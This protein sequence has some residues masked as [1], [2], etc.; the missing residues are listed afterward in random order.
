[1]RRFSVKSRLLKMLQI[2]VAGLAYATA[3]TANGQELPVPCGGSACGPNG[4]AVWVA[5]GRATASVSGNTMT[6]NQQTDSATLNWASFN[7][8]PDGV[9][10]FN[11]P[12]ATSVALNRIFQN[13][14]SR[15]FGAL[16][17][18]GQVYLINQNGILFGETAVV[19]VAGLIAS[20]LDLTTE[21]L[22]SGIAGAARS[23]AAAFALFTDAEGNVLESAAVT[24]ESGAFLGAEGGQ[25]YLFAP[26]V[27][28]RGTIETPD[29]QT[30]L[31]AGDKVYLAASSDP[32]LR[33]LFVEVDGE[34]VVTNGEAANSGR[35]LES[36]VGEISAARGNITMAALAVNQLGRV[37]ATTS[38]RQNGSIRLVGQRN[39]T[40]QTIGD[41][42]LLLANEGGT[43]TLG[44]NSA[45]EVL[46]DLD[47]PSRTVDVNE[48]PTSIIEISG[49]DVD[50]LAGSHITATSGDVSITARAN[51]QTPPER[52]DSEPTDSRLYIA[53]DV[54]IDVS[55]ADATLS[56]EDN[57]IDVELLGNQLRDSP[58]QRDGPL[59]GETVQVDIRDSGTH[60]DGGTW[61]GTPL[62]DASGEIS[63]IERG[64]A[65]RN[66]TGGSLS[67]SS[68]GDVIVEA[69]AILD[70]SGG[71]TTYEGGEVTTSRVLGVDGRVYDMANADRDREYVMVVDAY[72]VEHPRWGVTEVFPGFP[73]ARPSFEEGYVEGKDAGTVNILTPRAVFDGQIRADIVAGRYQRLPATPV[74]E[75]FLYRPFDQLPL[76]G[77]LIVGSALGLGPPPNYVLGDVAFVGGNA[78]A[79]LL[80]ADGGDFDPLVDVL[81]DDYVTRIDPQLFGEGRVTDGSVFSNGQ[82]RYGEET[83]IVLPAQGS[84]TLNGS[85][86]LF[87]GGFT[88]AGGALTIVGEQTV[89][90]FEDVFVDVGAAATI[91]VA[92]LWT[93][94]NPLLGPATKPI[95]IDGGSVELVASRGDLSVA[96]GSR[97]D[98]S[99][100]A[101]RTDGGS[102][103][104]GSGGSVA[105]TATARDAGLPV[106][107]S[108]GAELIGYGLFDGASLLISANSICIADENCVDDVNE[109]WLTPD[110]YM[111]QGF[112][113]I[114]LASNLVGL[115]LVAGTQI[116]GQQRNFVLESEVASIVSGTSLATFANVA[117]LPEVDR[118]PMRLALRSSN[119][120]IPGFNYDDYLTTPGL[121]LGVDTRIDMDAG[122]AVSLA[123][124]ALLVV[125]GAIAARGGAVDMTLRNSLL[126]VVGQPPAG[127]WIGD[128]ASIDVSG[129]A[130]TQL[131]EFGLTR[132]RVLDGGSVSI[133]AQRDGISLAAGSTINVSGTA[134]ELDIIAGTLARPRFSTETIGSNG[135]SL[136]LAAAE[137]I[138]A[139][140]SV[141][142]AGGQAP[143]TA[144]GTLNVLMD[145]A[146]RGPDPRGGTQ[147]PILSLDARRILVSENWAPFLLGVGQEIPADLIGVARIDADLMESAGFDN[148]SLTAASLFSQRFGT[149][150]LASQG[151]IGFL[152][153]TS[154]TLPGYLLLDAPNISGG[155]GDVDLNANYVRLGHANRVTQ[156]TGDA[157]AT[158]AGGLTVNAGL[159]DFLGNIRVKG[160]EAIRFESRG[161]IRATGVQLRG[162]RELLGALQTD[163]ALTLAA[164]QIYPTTLSDFTFQVEG[165]GRSVDILPVPGEPQLLLSAGGRLTID[166]DTIRQSGVL[167]APFG[168]LVLRGRSAEFLDGSLTSTS[169]EASLVP[170]GTIQIG[171]DW[172]F[173]L[174][175]NETLVF[176][177]L[178]ND[179][180][181][182]NVRIDAEDVSLGSGAVIDVSA[183]GDLLAYEFVPGVGGSTDYLSA[184]ESPGLFAILPGASINFA[185]IDPTES[186][187]TALQIGDTVF[188]DGIGELPAGNYTLLPAR[189]ALLPG[190]LLISPV[191]GYTDIL[192]GQT[193]RGA[194]GS[195]IVSG[196]T[197]VRGTDVVGQ[198]RQG[199]ALL[200]RSRA[201]AEAQYELSVAS[202]FF[203]GTGVRT[204]VDAG[205]ASFTAANSLA[206]Q[207][208]LRADSEFGRG[209]AL[210]V[211]SDFL[212]VVD[213]ATGAEGTVEILASD[214]ESLGAESI[215]LGG[216]RTSTIDGDVVTVS[217]QNVEV[218]DG[219]SLEGPDIILVASNEVRVGAGAVLE[220]TESAIEAENVLVSGDAALVRV[221]ADRQGMLV[222]DA[223]SGGTGDIVI[224]EAA[225]LRSEGS[226]T[227]DASRDVDSDG[228]YDIDGGVLRLG[229]ASI[230]LGDGPANGGLQLGQEALAALDA[231]EIEFVSRGLIEVYGSITLDV[232]ERLTLAAAGIGAGVIDGQVEAGNLVL[233]APD[234]VLLGITQSEAPALANG[235][236]NLTLNSARLTVGDGQF[237]LQ[238][239]ENS[240]L[241][242]SDSVLFAGDGALQSAGDLSIAAG[243]FTLATGADYAVQAGGRLEL[244]QFAGGAPTRSGG[245]GG[246][247]RLGGSTVLLGGNIRAEAGIVDVYAT[248]PDG[249]VTIQ[250]GATIDLGGVARE[251]ADTELATPGGTLR[252]ATDNGDIVLEAGST[253]DVS[254][255]LDGKA[256]QLVLSAIE[257][258]IE[259]GAALLG[260]SVDGTGGRFIADALE[261][262]DLGALLQSVAEGGFTDLIGVRLRGEGDLE[263]AAGIRV[264]GN[265]I[266]LQ[267]DRGGV[268]VDG[269]LVLSGD[270]GD[271]EIAARDDIT[272]GGMLAASGT[273]S[274]MLLSSLG[275]GL[276]T[277][278]GSVV[279]LAADGELL[280]SLTRD[281]L[282]TLLDGNSL[283]DAVRLDGRILGGADIVVEARQHYQDADGVID[284]T[285]TAA[286]M[287]NERYRDAVEFMQ[288]ADAGDLAGEIGFAD[289]AR[290]TVLPGVVVD[291]D[292]DLRVD[293]EFNLFDWRF[294]EVPGIL[295]LRATGD[296]LVNESINDGFEAANTPLLTYTGESWSYRLVA[297]AD[298][299]AAS[300]LGVSN[301]PE[302][303]D[304]VLGPGTPVDITTVRTGTGRIDVAA[305]GDFVLGNQQSVLYTSGIATDGVI[306]S[307]R[308][309]IGNRLY[310]DG[311]GDISIFAGRD[312]LGAPADQLVTA[313]LW[314][315]GR[316]PS[317]SQPVAT[318]WTI[319]FRSFQQNVGA[320]GGGDVEI[321]A[322]NNVVDLS[323]SIPSIGRQVGGRTNAESVVEVIA[324]GDLVVEAGNDILGGVYFVGL[325]D[326]TLSAAGDFG[327]TQDGLAPILGLGDAS[328]NV[329]ARED[330]ELQTVLNPTLLPQGRAQR[331]SPGRRSTFTTYSPDSA[332]SLVSVAGDIAT[333]DL[334]VG[335]PAAEEIFRQFT[336]LTFSVGDPVALLVAPPTVSASALAGNLD[337]GGSMTLYPSATG[338]LSLFADGDISLGSTLNTLQLILSDI[339]PS[340][341]PN[342]ETPGGLVGITAEILTDATS[343][344]PEF[345]AR[346]P[347]HLND[348]EPVRIVSR[349]GSIEML[350]PSITNRPTFFSAK[351]VRV[352]AGTDIRDFSLY[353]QNLTDASVTALTAGRDIV[354]SNERTAQGTLSRNNREITVAGPGYLALRAGRD[355]DLQT[356][357]GISTIGNLRNLALADDGASISAIAGLSDQVP[358][359]GAF[360]SAYLV[361]GETYDADLIAYVDRLVSQGVTE[362]AQA[363]QLYSELD[364]LL[365]EVFAEQVFLAELRASGREAATEGETRDDYT[366]GFAAIRLLFPESPDFSSLEGLEQDTPEYEAELERILAESP[367]SGD[368]SLFFSRMYT[369]DGGTVQLLVPGGDIN[370]GLATPPAAL[371]L[372]KSP[373]ELGIVAQ[374]QGDI[375]AFGIGDFAVNE[376][377]VF[378]ADGGN[379]L[380]WSSIGD[381][382]AGRGARTAIS[383]PPPVI[384]IDPET[385]ATQLVFPAALTGSGIQT[386]ATS[387]GTE[388]GDVDLYAP[389]GVVRASDAGIT[390]GNLFVSRNFEAGVT[391][392]ADTITGAE[393]PPPPAGLVAADAGSAAA[394]AGQAAE[395]TVA[396]GSG[397]EESA[398]P[399]ADTA[400]GWLDVFVLGFGDCD[401]ETGE[402]CEEE[403][404]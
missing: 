394:T 1:M 5:S 145:A 205:T 6:V 116:L 45:T 268:N 265:D 380:I 204:P 350:A 235:A 28:N 82:I 340:I 254:A 382:D 98:V 164:Q 122:S 149:P 304:F 215:L 29:G 21:A 117:L 195:L 312:V 391:T 92:G 257:G 38:I 221:N 298:R 366:R 67:I 15:I 230:I 121:I 54:L 361:E 249:D 260:N 270:N 267:A 330:I 269:E 345:N 53:S 385:G 388:P 279:D 74:P 261:F 213:S 104:A 321:V 202:E 23:N 363:L 320:L 386:L 158:N 127:I 128:A 354:F 360:I 387:P 85:S 176:D 73:G 259:S 218:G 274:R 114:S 93:N 35:T 281:T 292:G 194:D 190:A 97:I 27:A 256:G 60:A 65:E 200:D 217:S 26:E 348:D 362:K 161:D 376:S 203:A 172:T 84:L 220:A 390:A 237:L 4:P 264:T 59:R 10:N 322:G 255:P 115:E 288:A 283:N 302:V 207:G 18:N 125:D 334:A 20:S 262:G 370:A 372:Q 379:I 271:L 181:Q 315:A 332:L 301:D 401:P 32:N 206:L 373:S 62:A 341:L 317:S 87:D 324:G 113:D 52:F 229:A 95:V 325:G 404:L 12:N 140:G 286:D 33:G 41:D 299:T 126:G 160:F 100:G 89:T 170:F 162:G 359:Y 132:G 66:L 31:A 3:T 156:E 241:N 313:W 343:T 175:D 236:G 143:G 165:D 402:N 356:S 137:Y 96:E 70:I 211:A 42:T 173:G 201:F 282:A 81:P 242:A 184:S 34:G 101:Y 311:G 142:A 150:F 234:I 289:D 71:V 273:S 327:R 398:T 9:V 30:I 329:M 339:D 119:S 393:P 291:Y 138:L 157:A 331:V 167:R 86:V 367:Y 384:T 129:I 365:Q 392:T 307:G 369:L 294:E 276:L 272:L 68:E 106:S 130:I 147:E 222:R 371:G 57:I 50:V 226:I 335:A 238:G 253:I 11:Q 148:V 308:G 193:F 133:V 17:A 280:I 99:G 231:A 351:P 94:D 7:I 239:F 163:A 186:N 296:L 187:E 159:I 214:L 22:E 323:A 179:F 364:P 225:V 153:G 44:E 109:L 305:A 64:V 124:D 39:V 171:T 151:E 358:D 328:M 192:P 212:R 141:A 251:F 36:L 403:S 199:F 80:G 107:V 196:R 338:N 102:I 287:A 76:G 152:G 278:A 219:V 2:G 78:L 400:L 8:G 378:A 139:N 155:F 83:S 399:L 233:G 91:D 352:S 266:R 189:Y 277:A 318:G 375:L 40:I 136:T 368:I 174:P 13:D 284:A 303:G 232:A 16:N 395:T 182:Q 37:S 258:T 275:G 216:T 134:A 111:A 300:L 243:L 246:R 58:F 110:L 120:N 295:S 306:L 69:G 154:L 63:N 72:T 43:V 290:F 263:I 77:R 224:E 61:Q 198:R 210:D 88:A 123:S 346:V 90:E 146:L 245:P 309:D 25:I 228:T 396:E 349:L 374:R 389:N 252:L 47:D 285:E 188:L 293:A 383:A 118:R 177:G 314:R 183:G 46:L 244:G 316:G 48:Q 355:I 310:P 55:G 56:V 19:N 185:P 319:D 135:G 108:I 180:P 103:F 166:A 397:Q 240:I 168:E 333:N 248:G 209:A 326:A 24:V 75:G 342:V 336:S 197:G 357:L 247:L 14:P 169:L 344:R 297:G 377:R 178:L 250:S 105:F 79:D 337:I 144:G 353:V 208:E 112:A 347:L 49:R 227:V 223:V 191:A 131:D 51:P 381:I